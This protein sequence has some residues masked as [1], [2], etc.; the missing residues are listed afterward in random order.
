M[1]HQNSISLSLPLH[2]G[3]IICLKLIK[4]IL[5]LRTKLFSSSYPVPAAPYHN[6]NQVLLFSRM[7]NHPDDFQYVCTE[8]QCGQPGLQMSLPSAA[9][10][11]GRLRRART[12]RTDDRFCVINLLPLELWWGEDRAR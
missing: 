7:T 6:C 10:L 2:H 9:M 8:T 3:K 4:L 5:Q 11:S 12:M 1:R